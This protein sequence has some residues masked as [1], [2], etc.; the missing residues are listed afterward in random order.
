MFYDNKDKFM[1][2]FSVGY[3]CEVFV[4]CYVYK[5]VMKY[6]MFYDEMIGNLLKSEE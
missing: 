2:F 4:Y 1:C 6:D 3:I 5:V